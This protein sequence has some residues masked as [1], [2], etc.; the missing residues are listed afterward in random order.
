MTTSM[1]WRGRLTYLAMSLVVAWHTFAIMVAPMPDSSAMVQSFRYVLQPYLSLFRLDNYWNFFAPHVGK[2]AQFRYVIEDGAG[3]GHTYVPAD[4]LNGSLPR[5]VMWREFKYL[6]EGVMEAPEIRGERVAEL[7]CRKHAALNPVAV[8]LLSVQEQPFW[9]ED[10]LRGRRPLDPAYVSV[11]TL[12]RVECP[13]ASSPSSSLS[14]TPAPVAAP[15][16]RNNQADG[17]ASDFSFHHGA[18]RIGIIPTRDQSAT[19]ASEPT[20]LGSRYDD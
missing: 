13:S 7:L 10:Y 4:E 3:K 9:P 15:R 19:H 14:S 1:Q 5:Y 20:G 2:H 8:T 6:Y 12:R 16:H 11:N 17:A 18:G